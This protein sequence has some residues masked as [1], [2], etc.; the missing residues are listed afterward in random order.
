MK[1]LMR[2]GVAIIL[3]GLAGVLNAVYLYQS[4]P[5]PSQYV[6]FRLELKRGEP[7]TADHLVP[8][9]IPG[10]P[11]SLKRAFIPWNDRTLLLQLVPVRNF[12]PGDVVLNRDVDEAQAVASRKL[13]L[14][15][16][17]V[18]AVG[19]KFK[20]QSGTDSLNSSGGSNRVTIVVKQPQLEVAKANTKV[21][22]TAEQQA[23]LRNADRMIRV[24]TRQLNGK[25]IA[26]E[27]RIWGVAVFPRKE[28]PAAADANS[29]TPA[30]PM[31]GTGTAKPPVVVAPPEPPP[32]E[33]PKDDEMALT[34]SLEGI[35]SVP[36]V[37]LVGGEIG[38]FMLPEFP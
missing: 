7:I 20:R 34:V 12:N 2:V 21:K 23:A 3:A 11:D 8:L 38:F 31:T 18:V 22:P 26:P 15:K 25:E 32:I 33:Q 36:A 14:L 16:F 37:I 4:Q 28:V 19:D 1:S 5:K 10:N 9:G 29:K 35:E 13:E 17:R 30:K 6:A 27:D 24:V